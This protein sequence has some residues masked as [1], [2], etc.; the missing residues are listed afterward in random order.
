MSSLNTI[1]YEFKENLKIP[2]H[3]VTKGQTENIFNITVYCKESDINI[4][5]ELDC[6]NFLYLLNTIYQKR[7]TAHSML[8]K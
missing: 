6:L 8:K 4:S 2:F 5:K 7:A 1:L 3:I